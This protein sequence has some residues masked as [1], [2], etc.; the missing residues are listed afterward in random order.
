MRAT[1][2]PWAR[3]ATFSIM[4][5]PLTSMPR[6]GPSGPFGS[7][8]RKAYSNATNRTSGVPTAIASVRPHGR[9]RRGRRPR[10][11]RRRRRGRRRSTARRR[12]ARPAEGRR[13]RACRRRPRRSGRR[14]RPGAA[15]RARARRGTRRRGR[16]R[17]A[18]G[19]TRPPG[20]D[21]PQPVSSSRAPAITAPPTTASSS[22]KAISA[23]LRGRTGRCGTLLIVGFRSEGGAAAASP[24]QRRRVRTGLTSP[25]S[26]APRRPCGCGPRR[27]R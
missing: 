7:G 22:A 25:A 27:R 14:R 3:A 10:E 13:A 20:P 17:C 12:R 9:A 19:S 15:P 6:S 5:P 26:P 1:A 8:A 18:A 23:V 16:S 4:P 2:K 21:P 24:G 11:G